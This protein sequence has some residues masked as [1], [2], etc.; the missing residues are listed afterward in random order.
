MEPVTN[1][2]PPL[3][4]VQFKLY[5]AE[6]LGELTADMKSLVGNGQ[7]GRIGQLEKKVDRHEWYFAI[8]IGGA[9]VGSYMVEHGW[10][11]VS[12]IFGH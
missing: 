12:V 7:P 9:M 5:V 8:A 11:I 1:P 10:N 4:D 2:P 3:D 6:K